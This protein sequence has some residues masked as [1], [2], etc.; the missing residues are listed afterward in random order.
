MSDSGES[1]REDNHALWEEMAALHPTTAI[2]DVDG[3][4]AGRDDL[5]PWEPDELGSV[6]G[7]DLIHL[8]C[9]IGTDTIGWARRGA[10]VT[11][12]DFSGTALAA[13]RDLSERCGVDATWIEADVYDAASAVGGRTFDV[14][15]TGVG[16]LTWLPDVDGW[17]RVV[18]SLL[19]PGGRLYLMELHPMWEALIEDGRTICQPAVHAPM[20]R[21]VEPDRRSYAAPNVPLQHTV[22]QERLHSLGEVVT[23]VLEAGLTLELLHEHDV[24]PAPTAWLVRGPDRLYHFPPDAHPFPVC[25]SL[26]A[27]VPG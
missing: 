18:R 22:S 24:T 21:W 19:K 17:A 1:W 20:Q 25:Y 5:R 3:L 6:E 4:V 11:G 14:V 26:L 2:Y 8:Q 7:L 9:H 10:R 13:A 12:V 15:Y 27:S 16:A 23:A